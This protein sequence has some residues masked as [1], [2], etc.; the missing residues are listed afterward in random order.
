MELVNE[1]HRLEA[2]V[3]Q[4]GP[5][6]AVLRE[7]LETLVLL[8][9]PFAPHVCEEMWRRLGHEGGPRPGRPGPWPT[10]PSPARTRSSWRCRSTARCA[11]AITVPREAPGG[12]DA[13]A[14]RSRSP[15]WPSML[16]GQG[17][18]EGAWSCPAGWSA[19]WCGETAARR[20]PGPA[21]PRPG[22][23]RLRARGPGITTDPTIKRI[24]VP[25]FKDRTG[26]PG[27][28]QKIT[29]KVI[30]ELLKRGRFD[31]VPGRDGV[32]AL[33]EGE[34][35]AYTTIPIGFSDAGR[36]AR[37]PRPA[38]TRSSL[39][40]RVV[41]RKIG[42][43]EP[44]WQNEAFSF[45]D[46]YDVGDDPA[47]LLRP[48]GADH[49]PPRR[50]TSR[51]N[52]VAA[53]ARGVLAGWARPA[54]AAASTRSSGPTRTWP[55]QALEEPARGG[56]GRAS[57][58]RR[59]RSC[60]ATRRTWERRRWTSAR[61]RLAVRGAPRRRGARG[62]RAEGRRARTWRPTSTTR[63]PD[64]TLD[65]SRREARQATKRVEADPEKATVARGGAAEGR[66]RSRAYVAERAAAARA[67]R[68][69]DDALERAARA[70]GPGPAAADGR[71][72]QAR[73]LRRRAARP[74][75]RGRGRGARAAGWRSRSTCWATRSRARE[76][77]AEL[78]SRSRS[79]WRTARRRRAD[80][81][82]AAP[83]A[84]AGARAASALRGRAGAARRDGARLGLPPNMAFKVDALLEAARRWTDE[85]LRRGARALGAG[86]PARED[87]G[88]MPRVAL[89]AAVAEACRGSA[90]RAV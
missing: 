89:A 47:H 71:D 49:R 25:L 37:R 79:C 45:R 87:A 34:I 38:A 2:E 64:V 68:S 50:S 42:Q 67:A 53:D 33:V 8:L 21:A 28:D 72:R 58:R 55:R 6:R 19:W 69:T 86:R 60:A 63:R 24:G 7:A 51:R 65:A 22:R 85:D 48:R 40:A 29:Q 44:I 39:T 77:A 30:E 12:G 15:G 27:L 62:R 80:P 84:A 9:N 23:L 56:A 57:A 70:G 76:P 14:R 46:E 5:G 66:A 82:R 10:R 81:G 52:L 59:C 32:D 36:R 4:S 75:G 18:R 61:T 26:K 78:S 74:H 41:Y 90:A 20:A 83:R 11:A 31:V 1:I 73:G 16:D 3:A 17:G 54:A 35:L 13:R 43:K 88:R